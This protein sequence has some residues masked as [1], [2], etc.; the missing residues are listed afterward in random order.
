MK[1]K[2]EEPTLDPKLVNWSY[3]ISYGYFNFRK[4]QERENPTIIDNSEQNISL[5]VPYQ[6]E[7]VTVVYSSAYTESEY[8]KKNDLWFNIDLSSF[9]NSSSYSNNQLEQQEG[10]LSQI[11]EEDSDEEEK[12]N[13]NEIIIHSKVL[14]STDNLLH[15]ST[16]VN[17]SDQLNSMQIANVTTTHKHN[18]CAKKVL[19]IAGSGLIGVGGGLAMMPI[20]NDN[21]WNLEEFGIHVHEEKAFFIASTINTLLLVSL[22]N[23]LGM[24]KHL[25][26][27]K[28]L[29]NDVHNDFYTELEPRLST[30][31]KIK[32]VGYE[33]LKLITITAA[34]QPVLMLW[35]IEL[36][37][38]SFSEDTNA[39]DEFTAW[40]TFT[41][42]PLLLYKAIEN[43][44]NFTKTIESSKTKHIEL[45]SLGSKLFVYGLTALSA[46][47]RGIALTT[48]YKDLLKDIGVEEDNAIITSVILG[49]IVANGIQGILE[50]S[51]IQSLFEKNINHLS[52]RDIAKGIFSAIEGGWF[53]LPTIAVGLNAIENMNV[54][55]KMAIF[56]PT[57]L[58]RTTFESNNIYESFSN[59]HHNQ[60]FLPTSQ[61]HVQDSIHELL[62]DQQVDYS[63]LD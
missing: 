17:K 12:K 61:I 3:Q 21:I 25:A 38:K 7:K 29:K 46:I 1:Q 4:T 28:Q 42:A 26:H 49:G 45:D 15:Y 16:N 57:F 27:K 23:S 60:E 13:S 63:L 6:D 24:Y 56:L 34:L 40:A 32:K 48:I 11:K 20:I 31:D 50:Y 30:L 10:K 47:G 14:E 58:S 41:T 36:K 53:A 39:F 5:N 54:L 19:K 43:Y 51:H 59:S 33:G 8:L 18:H 62:G 44:S 22:C 9:W 55:L 52:I 2:I 35:D 37:D